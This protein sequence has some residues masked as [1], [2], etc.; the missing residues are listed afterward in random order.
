MTPKAPPM[1]GR[2]VIVT[3]ACGIMGHQIVQS[4]SDLGFAV[5][6]IDRE[7]STLDN[8]VE[9]VAC[10]ITDPE[11]V[12]LA[13]A[14]FAG[15]ERNLYG[16][17]NCAAIIPTAGLWEIHSKQFL[18]TIEVNTWGTLN[19]SREAAKL[20]EK[21]GPGR[22]INVAS[23]AGYIG[24]LVGGPDYAA[25]KAGVMVLT[26]ILAKE[27]ASRGITVNT[28]APGA[29]NSRAT[30]ALDEKDSEALLTKIPLGRLGE[31]Q[32][33]VHPIAHLLSEGAGYITG[34][35]IDVNG[36]AYLR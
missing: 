26:K 2:K 27:L 36:G 21:N 18:K 14:D 28:V 29:L 31:I 12:R 22:I 19:T 33:I 3:G 25:S 11:K 8:G 13:F 30:E 34:S 1:E 24:G 20:M 35:T 32:E 9:V 16:I 4:V 23:V 10:D 15:G 7:S 6:G 5:L 17:V